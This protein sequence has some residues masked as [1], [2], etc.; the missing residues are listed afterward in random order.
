MIEKIPGGVE[1][2][3]IGTARSAGQLLTHRVTGL[4]KGENTWANSVNPERSRTKATLP[5]IILQSKSM[6][7]GY[8]SS[9]P[10][11]IFLKT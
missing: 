2:I 11:H 6:I 3:E 10:T 7:K 4:N 1:A 9:V 5:H 8:L